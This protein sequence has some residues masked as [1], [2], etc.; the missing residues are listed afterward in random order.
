[1][2]TARLTDIGARDPH[3]LVISGRRQHLL[4]QIAIAGLQF[5]LFAQ[6]VTCLAN[7]IGKRIANS[8]E[9]LEPRNPRFRKAGGNRGVEGKSRKGLSAEAGKLVLEAADLAAQ[10]C[11]REA[12]VAPHSKRRQ[13][14]SIE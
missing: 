7:A 12:L 1:M 3:P 13:R 11:A 14:V 10:L 4:E 6:G 8:L 2:A 9:L 5:V